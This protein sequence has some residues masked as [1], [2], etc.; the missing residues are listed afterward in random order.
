MPS[1][2]VCTPFGY[3]VAHSK[4]AQKDLRKCLDTFS[5]RSTLNFYRLEKLGRKYLLDF[6]RSEQ[7]LQVTR[8]EAIDTRSPL[9]DSFIV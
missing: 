6:E 9:R 8:V 4:V 3:F 1:Y 5:P 2:R 7:I